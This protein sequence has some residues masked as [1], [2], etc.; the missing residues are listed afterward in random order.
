MGVRTPWLRRCGE[1]QRDSMDALAACWEVLSGRQVKRTVSEIGKT[2]C[3]GMSP[4][5]SRLHQRVMRRQ[6][7]A[8][9]STGLVR[10]SVCCRPE[11][12]VLGGQLFSLHA[13]I[14]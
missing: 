2:K 11:L 14:A 12:S 4:E 10:P 9:N 5:R 7:G 6:S 13:K 1:V 3:T 8:E